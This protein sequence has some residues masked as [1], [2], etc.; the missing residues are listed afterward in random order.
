MNIFR[1]SE[2]QMRMVG[3]QFRDI[4]YYRIE[5]VEKHCTYS[6]N[7]ERKW[8]W[9]KEQKKHNLFNNKKVYLRSWT[10]IWGYVN[11]Y[12]IHDVCSLFFEYHTKKFI[13][14]N[15]F[16]GSGHNKWVRN[17]KRHCKLIQ[18]GQTVKRSDPIRS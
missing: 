4:Y 1:I 17:M 13:P 3:T 10:R 6:W 15:A 2:R 18:W 7:I 5:H 16:V 12:T 11:V 8:K 14:L 9:D